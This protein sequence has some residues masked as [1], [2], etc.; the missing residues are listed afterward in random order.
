MGVNKTGIEIHEIHVKLLI[1]LHIKL[2]IEL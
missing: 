1:E 2:L